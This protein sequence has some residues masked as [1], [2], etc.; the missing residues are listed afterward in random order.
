MTLQSGKQV[1]TVHIYQN[2]SRSKVNQKIKFGEIIE[3][4]MRNNLL[5]NYTL[6]VVEMLQPWTQYCRQIHEIK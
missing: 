2:P 3:Y 6:N 4:N 1:I 5:K